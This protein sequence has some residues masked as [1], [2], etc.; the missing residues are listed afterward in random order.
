MKKPIG[1][2]DVWQIQRIGAIAASPDGTQVAC[3]VTSYSM[4]ENQ[5]STQLWL[6]C[7]Q[8]GAP[9]QLTT[10]GERDGQPAW[11]PDGQ[12]IAFTA[13]REGDK[14]AQL[15]LIRAN[16]GEARRIGQ[17]AA[18]VAA[19]RWMPGSKKLVFIAWVWPELKGAAAQNKRQREF[20]ERKESGYATSE[21]QYRYWS[22]NLPMG[23]VAHLLT[24]DVGSG[25]VTDLF[26]GTAYELPRDEPG[27][28]NFDL[29]PDGRSALFT[30]DAAEEKAGGNRCVLVELDLR[31]KRFTTLADHAAWDFIGPRYSPDGRH[32]AAVATHV[33]R[34]HTAFGQLAMWPSERRFEPRDARAWTHDVQPPL[35]W[36]ADGLSMV[37]SAEEHGRCHT[38]R[39]ELASREFSV[40]ARGGWVQGVDLAGPP[41]D[42]TLVTLV[43]SAEHPAQV[44]AERRG[45]SRRLESFNDK[46]MQRLALGK[47]GEHWI[48]GALGEKVQV[49][50]I[51][52]P[53]L[54]GTKKRK[55]PVLQVIH[56][57]PYTAF[58]D[59]FSFRWNA[60]LLASRGHVVVQTNYH[61]SSGFGEDFRASIMGRQGQLEL[62]DLQATT[63]WILAQPWADA[64]RVYAAGA[65]YGGYLV[66]WMNGHWK[67]W[68]QGPIRAYVCH[69]GVFDRI[70]TWSAD[71]YTQRHRDLGAT[72]WQ[73][74]AL[75]ESQ[76]PL[77]F[78]GAMQTPTLVIHG[79]LDYRVPDHNGLAYYNTLKVRGVDARLLWFPDENH[80]VL[81]PR[82]AGQWIGE[83]FGWL[84]RHGGKSPNRHRRPARASP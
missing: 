37:F 74:C 73:D 35:R 9:R 43:D 69:A 48:S 12:S 62:Q 4:Q 76:S 44:R 51:H 82:N 53:R 34:R 21:G 47:V 46:L 10:C 78:A 8:G 84:E 30:F 14:A 22:Q 32:I 16:G 58:G 13:T 28:A 65:S 75:V 50:A 31:T 36:A 56:G 57:G 45:Q 39:H 80:W 26:E 66:A 6:L 61:G 29:S 77:T 15:H 41:G 24:I 70:A 11:S 2:D 19:F 68:P 5:G 60:H 40:A 55:Q 38:W 64:S 79:A 7:T 42:E 20:D 71:S 54:T 52:P 83:F 72:Y 3:T 25:K 33:G 59:S 63:D 18:G 49:W 1:V 17:F 81:K 27:M 23:R 67:P